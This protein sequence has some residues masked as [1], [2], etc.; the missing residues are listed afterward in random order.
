MARN[1]QEVVD[2]VADMVEA[3][4]GLDALDRGQQFVAADMAVV[5][6]INP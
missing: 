6:P 2:D 5:F 3:P 1:L 4:I